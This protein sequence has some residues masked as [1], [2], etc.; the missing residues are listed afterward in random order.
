MESP[1]IPA[2][3]GLIAILVVVGAAI[4]IG[5]FQASRRGRLHSRTAK[6][7]VAAVVAIIAV[8][9]WLGPAAFLLSD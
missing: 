8:V 2:T 9:V 1:G 5:A 4:I 3:I 6:L 7:V